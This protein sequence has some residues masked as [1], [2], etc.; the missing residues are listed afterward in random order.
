MQLI[1]DHNNVQRKIDGGFKLYGNKDD[2]LSLVAQIK[3]AV[4][5]KFLS[6][7]VTVVPNLTAANPVILEWKM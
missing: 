1:I 4:D 6:G 5:E 2:L 7:W 3:E